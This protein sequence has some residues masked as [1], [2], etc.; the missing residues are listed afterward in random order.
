MMSPKINLN[1]FNKRLNKETENTN[2]NTST[3]G[4]NKDDKRKIMNYSSTID[5]STIK[6]ENEKNYSSI[7]QQKNNTIHY[8]LNT[9]NEK[10]LTNQIN[11]MQKKINFSHNKIKMKGREVFENLIIRLFK[12]FII[13]FACTKET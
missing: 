8:D 11:F 3:I 10:N 6:K 7:N 2:N 9:S 13:E 1:K 5:T 12:F 4:E